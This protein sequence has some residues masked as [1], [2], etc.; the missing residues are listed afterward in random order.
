M[1]RIMLTPLEHEPELGKAIGIPELYFKREDLHPYGSHK[2]RSI[3][4]M[5]DYYYQNGDRHFAITGSG[6]AALAAALYVN[7]KNTGM[8]DPKEQIELEIYVGN[9]IAPHKFDKIKKV[10]DLSSEKTRI[11][12]RERPLQALTVAIA[13]GMRSLRQS[14][15]D[16]ALM[17]YKSLS[18]ELSHMPNLSTI[19]IAS[20]SG[21]TAEALASF[22]SSQP[23]NHLKK[24][25]QVVR[26]TEVHI[27]QTSSCH[28]LADAFETYDGPDEKSA[29]DAIV[30]I[31]AVR[32]PKL[33][34][35]LQKCG[36]HGWV[37]SNEEIA[38]A[39]ELTKKHTDLDISKNSALSV[40][41]AMLASYRGWEMKGAVVC[42]ICGD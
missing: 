42:V 36:G 41:G 5:M 17:G 23:L 40:A 8:K 26:S 28:V 24:E 14:T 13:E 20:S 19:F 32:K 27:V 11:F 39:Q 33:I 15:D 22:F 37:A 21:T 30:D 9:N 2:G 35:L 1:T 10:A 38:R 34:P 16:V 4:F 18:E 25:G 29:A 3:P 12:V 7:A 6:N 31:T